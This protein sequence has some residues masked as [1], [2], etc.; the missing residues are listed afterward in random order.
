[1]LFRSALNGKLDLDNVPLSRQLEFGVRFAERD[2]TRNVY[3]DPNGDTNTYLLGGFSGYHPEGNFGGGE[4]S[5][6]F[7]QMFF[8]TPSQLLA[9]LQKLDPATNPALNTSQFQPG[10][11]FK[12][13]EKTNAF[14]IQDDLETEIFGMPLKGNAGVRG[15]W[16]DESA[17]GYFQP[18]TIT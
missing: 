5:L 16:T 12:I 11:S 3:G 17:T 6:P 15:V 10:P 14:Y 9:A 8:M 13:A 1:M 18:F 2:V 7:N 4:F